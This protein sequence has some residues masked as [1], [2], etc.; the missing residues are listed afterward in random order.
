MACQSCTTDNFSKGSIFETYFSCIVVVATLFGVLTALLGYLCLLSL[1]FVAEGNWEVSGS[2]AQRLTCF[3]CDP[4]SFRPACLGLTC[5]GESCNS[6]SQGSYSALK[7]LLP[8]VHADPKE[9]TT[10]EES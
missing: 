2:V 1:Q 4:C 10:K 7:S 5:V 8:C 6:C 3:S 9:E